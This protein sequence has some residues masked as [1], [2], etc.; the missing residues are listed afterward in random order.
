MA[1]QLRNI[2]I[3]APAFKGLNTQDSPLSQDVQYASVVDNAVVDNYGRIGARKGLQAQ[4]TNPSVLN[5]NPLV[6]IHEYEDANGNTEV[7][8]VGNSNFFK[9]EGT[10][11][12]ITPVGY[13]ITNEHFKLINFND[14]CYYINK[15]HSPLVYDTTN[16][17]RLVSATAEASGTFP[18]GSVGMGGHGRLWVADGNVLYWSD[19]L[20]GEAWDTGSSGSIN[21]DKVWPD[22]SDTITALASWNG[23]LVIFGYNSIV[24]YQGA[25]DPATMSLADTVSGVGCVDQATVK[26]TGNDLLF[27]SSRGLMTLGRTI[28]E[29]SNP[30]N[31]VSRNVRDDLLS[32][33]NL[34]SQPLKAVYSPVNSFYLLLFPTNNVVY[35]FDTRGLLENGGYRVTRWVTGSHF[36]FY[37]KQDDTLIVGNSLGVSRYSGYTDNGQPYM[38]RYFSHPLSFGDPSLVKFLKKINTTLIGGTNT[39]ITARWGYDFDTN[40][41]GQAFKLQGTTPAFYNEDL[42]NSGAMYTEGVESVIVK[43]INTSGSG[44]LTTVGIEST[45][46]NAP[47]SIQEFN[48]QATIGRIY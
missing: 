22:G 44:N 18:N 15:D 14:K 33:W 2:T 48:I 34:E 16:G 43:R 28:Q 35:C 41:K 10:L 6:V 3:S 20:I 1:Q 26:A 45:I 47:L 37:S 19:L 32:L 40:Y 23:Y 30:I 5:N 38:F 39:E 8:S 4:T 25:Q 21:L 27:L 36:S 11:T 9:G 17:L 24:I 31:D 29:K 7:L 46:N 42:F 13:S 12:A